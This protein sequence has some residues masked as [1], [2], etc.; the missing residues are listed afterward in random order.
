MA[1]SSF[2]DR[3]RPSTRSN[4]LST[5]LSNCCRAIVSV[6]RSRSEQR[7]GEGRSFPR[8]SQGHARRR[9]RRSDWVLPSS[10]PVTWG[11]ARNQIGRPRADQKA[12]AFG[13]DLR[14]RTRVGPVAKNPGR[15][16][17]RLRGVSELGN[18]SPLPIRLAASL[19]PE[20]PSR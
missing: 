8:D 15:G 17:R 1:T 11:R 7:D 18:E 4:W 16:S 19:P 3:P 5:G 13:Q 14:F 6:P 12:V 2:T 10:Q 20:V 9:R